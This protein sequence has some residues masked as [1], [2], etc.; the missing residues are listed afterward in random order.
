MLRRGLLLGVLVLVNA[1]SG[2]QQAAPE[3][4]PTP[5]TIAEVNRFLETV[6][7]GEQTYAYDDLVA[8]LGPPIR[9]S[10]TPLAG[11]DSVR[12]LV[13]Y[14][15]E[16]GLREGALP[17][18]LVHLALTAAR[19]TAPEGLRVGY[20]ERQVLS[21]LG[22]PARRA[23]AQLIYEKARPPGCLLV[24]FLERRVISRLEWQFAE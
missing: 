24:V 22:R 4:T 16:V 23:P 7:A 15:L 1:C 9:Q 2:V 21:S 5:V 11:A 8:L 6:L 3:Q 17:P 13:Y 19:Y 10:A 12:T 20:A 18:R 14:G